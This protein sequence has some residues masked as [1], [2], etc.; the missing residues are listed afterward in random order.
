MPSPY[1]G[2]GSNSEL[3]DQPTLSSHQLMSH[4][5]STGN[6]G[7]ESGRVVGHRLTLKCAA[8]LTWRN[9]NPGELGGIFQPTHALAR[10]ATFRNLLSVNVVFVAA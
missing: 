3:A 5:T 2:L 8:M 10:G 6:I 1:R 9:T 7:R 4:S